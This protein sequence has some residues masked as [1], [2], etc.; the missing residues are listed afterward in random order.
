[1][2]VLMLQAA[3]SI[4]SRIRNIQKIRP[5][6]GGVVQINTSGAAQVRVGDPRILLTSLNA[7][8]AGS[9]IKAQGR[10][11]GDLTLTA[12]TNTSSQVNFNLDSDLGGSSIPGARNCGTNGRL[13]GRCAVDLCE[14]PLQPLAA[15]SQPRYGHARV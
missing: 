8:V 3:R 15:S 1:M 9:A 12:N 2:R 4:S 6:F 13:P 7:R 14:R 11:L 5:G 10:N